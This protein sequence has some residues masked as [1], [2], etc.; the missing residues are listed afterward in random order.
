MDE[1][2]RRLIPRYAGAAD[3][4]RAVAMRAYM[5]ELFPYLGIP[6]PARR[7][8]SR[9]VLAGLPPPDEAALTRVALACW[10]LPEREYQYFAVDYLRRHAAVLSPAALPLVRRLI[11]TRSWWD[12]V[13][14]IADVV[15]AMV[16]R[17]PGLVST[18]DE[19]AAGSDPSVGSPS[20]SPASS[21]L[22]ELWLARVAILHQTRYR[23]AT[24]TDR[25]LRYCAAQA[26]HRDFFI[27]KA[28]GW[29]LREHAKTDPDI[30]RD[31]IA[32]T[33]ELSGLSVREAHKHL[34]PVSSAR[35]KP[36]A[37]R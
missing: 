23:A 27:R 36:R 28:I 12:T 14:E 4:E 33:P 35:A 29:A 15:G 1:V 13:D 30:V 8:L 10:E 17:H 34:G 9:A 24:D 20:A 31:F 26:R 2:L 7:S 37:P 16:A 19:W 21:M 11:T 6:S 18:M 22:G 32:A 25:L 3:A 5:R